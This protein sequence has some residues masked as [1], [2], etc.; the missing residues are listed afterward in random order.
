MERDE[1]GIYDRSFPSELPEVERSR[2]QFSRSHCIHKR[3][4]GRI[5]RT[6][7]PISGHSRKKTRHAIEPKDNSFVVGHSESAR[8]GKWRLRTL[9]LRSPTAGGEFPQTPFTD[10]WH[11]FQVRCYT[12]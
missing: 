4:V 7:C 3:F 1:S 11:S 2:L 9:V 6:R 10:H 5:G 12:G 8:P